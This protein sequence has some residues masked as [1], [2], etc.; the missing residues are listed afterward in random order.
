[1]NPKRIGV[2]IF[3]GITLVLLAISISTNSWLVID[4][5]KVGL[6]KACFSICFGQ[7]CSPEICAV[8]KSGQISDKMLATR[9]FACFSLFLTITGCIFAVVRMCKEV[10]GKVA[11]G[12]F[13]GAGVCMVIALSIFTEENS[14]RVKIDRI[15]YGWSFILGWISSIFCFV[16][17][18]I[19][20]AF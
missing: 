1:M 8:I 18:A 16:A 13:L 19:N 5:G 15:S 3:S 20:C 7:Q 2:A 17:M 6:W 11:A 10:T 4:T 12:C 9:G 14:D